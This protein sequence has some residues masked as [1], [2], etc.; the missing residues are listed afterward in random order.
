MR[1][2]QVKLSIGLF[3]S[4]VLAFSYLWQSTNDS[5]RALSEQYVVQHLKHDAESILNA[6]SVDDKNK[7]SLNLKQ[8]EPVYLRP[9]SGQYYLIK[10]KNKLIRSRSLWDQELLIPDLMAGEQKIFSLIGPEKQPLLIIASGFNKQG[11]TYTI[12]VAEDITPT[13][14][15]QQN[16]QYKYS[17]TV[18]GLLVFLLACQV[19]ILRLS[20]RPLKHIQQQIKQLRQGELQQ[21]DLQVPD[22]VFDLV[23]EINHLLRV[24]ENRLERSRNALGDL[25]HALKIPL[26]V[27]QQ[28]TNSHTL[29][30]Q[31]EICDSLQK[32]TNNM[33]GV[34][35]RVLKQARFSGEGVVISKFNAREEVP[36]LIKV[37]QSMYR[38]KGISIQYTQT[39]KE[40]IAID[41][42]D[43]MELLG[44]LLDNACKWAKSK[45]TISIDNN[46]SVQI[47]IE[48]DGPGVSKENR[49]KL[50]KRGIRLDEMN[51]GHGLGLSIV[52]YMVEQYGGQ[53]KLDHSSQLGGLLVKV[54]L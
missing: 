8:I 27:I 25:A 5:I 51:E 32:Q 53:L 54:T 13:L 52:Q 20:F 40:V 31:P 21:I 45:I 23:G 2:I 11:M 3:I 37:L 1:S 18:G 29:K 47:M 26:T 33:Q 36:E 19:L 7:L 48:D 9:F 4:L 14:I 35:Q 42:E 44:N 17:Y 24:M 22:E 6:L 10:A 16:F 46:E 39:G 49:V 15:G 34:I 28:L 43:M 38:E 41:R 30:A 50:I 12:A